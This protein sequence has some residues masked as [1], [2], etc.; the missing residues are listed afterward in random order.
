MRH[1]G[2]T[3]TPEEEEHRSQTEEG[4]N[5]ANKGSKC[6]LIYGIFYAF[7]CPMAGVNVIISYGGDVV[8]SIA[9][10]LRSIIPAI[11][12][13]FY[14]FSAFIS[15]VF[16]KKY[17]RKALTF[18]GTIALSLIL[19]VIAIG[20]FIRDSMVFLSQ[21]LIVVFLFVYLLV[22]GLTYAPVMWMWVAEA[23]LP[24]TIG[25]AVM[26]NFSG[27]AIVMIFF[28]IIVEMLPGRNP[29]FIF[30]FFATYLALSLVVTK[31]LMIET[32]DK[33]EHE[34]MEE[35]RKLDEK[36]FGEGRKEDEGLEMP[37]INKK[38]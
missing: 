34:I 13:L 4:D 9:P 31:V 21:F 5:S 20:Y 23:L 11:L 32:K 35:Y 27:A 15:V 2:P 10:D 29:A 14:L 24:H 3:V 28:P 22:F 38:P 26:V 12:M 8:S 30:L 16:V 33:F 7:L 6:A 36:Y 25:Y 1:H 17:G 18:Y 19:I 37:M